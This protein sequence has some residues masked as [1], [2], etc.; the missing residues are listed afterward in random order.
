MKRQN[1]AKRKPES[2]FVVRI[3]YLQKDTWQG[4]IIWV[5]GRKRQYFRSDLEM[6][7][8]MQGVMEAK[9]VCV[10]FRP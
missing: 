3:R 6:I 1:E 8:L 7:K 4:E 9:E 2:T 5:D 10:V